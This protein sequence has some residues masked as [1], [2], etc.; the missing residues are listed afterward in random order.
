M[1]ACLHTLGTL[2][3]LPYMLLAVAFL[4]IGDVARSRGMLA[5][6]DAV[7]NHALWI[8]RWGIYG[9]FVFLVAFVVAG[10]L[11]S[12][13]RICAAGLFWMAFGSLVVICTL[14]STRMGLGEVTFLL[15]CIAVLG[16]SAWQFVR[17][18]TPPIGSSKVAPPSEQSQNPQR[19]SEDQSAK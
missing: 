9:L 19:P 3:V 8:F 16:M 17:E 10:F 18:R 1:N 13:Q 15:P 5:L 2:V 6:I 4:L 14:H 7:A 12:L 11:P